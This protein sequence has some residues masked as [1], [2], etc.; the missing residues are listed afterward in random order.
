MLLKLHPTFFLRVFLRVLYLCDLVA[1][2]ARLHGFL[3]NFPIQHLSLTHD[4]NRL[5]DHL[6]RVPFHLQGTFD[7]WVLHERH[8]SRVTFAG[9]QTKHGLLGDKISG[10]APNTTSKALGLFPHKHRLE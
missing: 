6:Y 4:C 7:R 1:G 9:A 2:S 5:S 10:G 3:A 8:L